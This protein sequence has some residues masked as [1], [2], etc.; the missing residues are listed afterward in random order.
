VAKGASLIA[1]DRKR[2]V[3]KQEAPERGLIGE[4]AASIGRV[5][6]ELLEV[7]RLIAI[8]AGLDRL[9]G[10]LRIGGNGGALIF[11]LGLDWRDDVRKQ[12]GSQYDCTGYD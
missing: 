11:I 3:V 9:D 5:G 10:C 12:D 7:E 8:D 4:L 6:K 2:F 1:F